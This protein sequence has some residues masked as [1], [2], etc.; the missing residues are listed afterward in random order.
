MI[1]PALRCATVLCSF[2]PSAGERSPQVKTPVSPGRRWRK[3]DRYFIQSCFSNFNRHMNRLGSLVKYKLPGKSGLGPESLHFWQTPRLYWCLDHMSNGKADINDTPPEITSTN[4]P[5]WGYLISQRTDL[6]W[7]LNSSTSN[8]GSN[9]EREL[10][11][12]IGNISIVV[13]DLLLCKFHHAV[14]YIRVSES[15]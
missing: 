3:W 12:F 8:S 6:L 10:F 15:S 9:P 5:S 2:T 7:C 11:K 1:Q 14:D 4:T 13:S